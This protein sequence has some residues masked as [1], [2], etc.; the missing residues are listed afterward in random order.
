MENEFFKRIG[1]NPIIAAVNNLDK[2]EEALQCPCEVIFLLIGNIF[3][4]KEIVQQVKEKNKEVYVHLDLM[5]GFAKDFISLK[6]IHDYIKPNGFISTRGSLVK[7]AKEMDIFIIQ[8]LFLLDALSLEKGL[9][10]VYS[11]KPDA[12]EVMPGI[13]PKMTKRIYSELKTPVITGG[14][15]KEKVDVIKSLE[16]GAVGVSTSKQDIWYM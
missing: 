5:E 4:L 16:V 11:T 15:I 9:K 7:I 6:Y 1:N 3:N 13:I 10:S 2:V 14:L 12:V 8:R